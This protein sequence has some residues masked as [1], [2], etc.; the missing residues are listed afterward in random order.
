MLVDKAVGFDENDDM[1]WMKLCKYYQAY[2][3]GGEQLEDPIKGLAMFSAY[4]AKEGKNV[5]SN[6]F[7]YNRIIMPRGM[8]AE[9]IPSRSGVYRITSRNESQNGVDGWIFDE[10]RQELL[11]YEQDERMFEEE[12]EVSMV[13]YMEKG[14][15][16]Y[17]DIAFWDPYEVGYIYYDIEYLGAT[18]EHFRLCSPGPFTYDSNATGDAMYHVIHGGIKAVLGEDGIYYVDL[19]NG[20][21]GS[22][23]YADFTGYTSLFNAPIATTGDVQGMID[24][25]GFDFSKNEEDQYIIAMMAKNDNDPEKTREYLREQWGEDYDANCEIYQVEDVLA[26]KYHGT[27][28]DMTP[29]ITKYLDKII[30][31][32]NPE[33]EGCVVV[34]KELAEILT[35]LMDK[36]TF[37]DVDQSWLKLCYYYDYLGP[38][39]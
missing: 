38:E 22:K 33:R 29:A 1:E 6:Y 26:G 23:I 2:G 31:D 16:Y 18:R 34:D 10:N 17:I 28:E 15:P 14:R 39:G 12:G 37:A 7:Y 4:T 5:E 27:G 11:V 25:G 36:Y 9:F 30:H 21:K 13:F 8:F 20:K 3:T 35:L 32:G 19:G 24:K